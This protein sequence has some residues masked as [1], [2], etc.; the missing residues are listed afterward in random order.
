MQFSCSH[1]IS[2]STAMSNVKERCERNLMVKKG[3]HFF[4]GSV[5]KTKPLFLPPRW[6]KSAANPPRLRSRNRER[7]LN[8]DKMVKPAKVRLVRFSNRSKEEESESV[9]PHTSTTCVAVRYPTAHLCPFYNRMVPIRSSKS[10]LSMER[11]EDNRDGC[12]CYVRTSR[13]HKCPI[14]HTVLG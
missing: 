5:Q 6:R 1:C 14:S 4:A 7:P 12:N 10:R 3:I 2:G 11:T 13:Y 8:P 9:L